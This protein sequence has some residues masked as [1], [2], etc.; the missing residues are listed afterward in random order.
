MPARTHNVFYSI[1]YHTILY[2]INRIIID[3]NVAIHFLRE[4]GPAR[5]GWS[6]TVSEASPIAAPCRECPCACDILTSPQSSR[7]WLQSLCRV[8]H[9]VTVNTQ[10]EGRIHLHDDM[11]R[12]ACVREPTLFQLPSCALLGVLLHIGT[13][14]GQVYHDTH[15]DVVSTGARRHQLLDVKLPLSPCLRT[16]LMWQALAG[17]ATQGAEFYHLSCV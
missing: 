13:L 15:F 4:D 7:I 12:R 11:S 14:C 9:T 10:Q 8:H 16:M 1:V 6:C 5:R 3:C 2:H 17:I